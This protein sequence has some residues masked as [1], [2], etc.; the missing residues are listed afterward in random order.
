MNE[1]EGGSLR[2]GTS[3]FKPTD[4]MKL[5]AWEFM[6]KHALP[7]MIEKERRKEDEGNHTKGS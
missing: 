2:E 4:E 3:D 6:K 1:K 7:R 5:K